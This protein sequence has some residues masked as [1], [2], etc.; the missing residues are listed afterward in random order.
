MDRNKRSS[1]SITVSWSIT[2]K[3]ERN[4]KFKL[5]K[6]PNVNP[7]AATGVS[8]NAVDLLI[9]QSSTERNHSMLKTHYPAGRPWHMCWMRE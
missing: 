1:L 3:L 2:I 4:S 9:L 5:W 8:H 6:F 7:K